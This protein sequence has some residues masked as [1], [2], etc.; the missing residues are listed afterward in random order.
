ME[1][2]SRKSLML[3]IIALFI[4]SCIS[5]AR[6]NYTPYWGTAYDFTFIVV[7]PIQIRSS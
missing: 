3:F 6:T 2:K 1:N 7:F 5:G 4:Q